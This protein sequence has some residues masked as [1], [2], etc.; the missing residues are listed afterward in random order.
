[1]QVDREDLKSETIHGS[2]ETR[3]ALMC[4]HRSSAKMEKYMGGKWNDENFEGSDEP[5]LNGQRAREQ[6][7]LFREREQ[8]AQL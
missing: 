7:R 4:S 1:M 8:M 5:G 3:G 6:R 2:T